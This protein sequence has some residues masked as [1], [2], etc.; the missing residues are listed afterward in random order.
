[1]TNLQQIKT[2]IYSAIGEL[3]DALSEHKEAN[4]VEAPGTIKINLGAKS[5]YLNLTVGTNTTIIDVATQDGELLEFF[6]EVPQLMAYIAN[7]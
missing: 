3:E 4:F 2:V 5:I 6:T 1:M 7:Y